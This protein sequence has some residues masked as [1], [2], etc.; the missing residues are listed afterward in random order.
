MSEE[1][2]GTEETRAPR[3]SLAIE[4]QRVVEGLRALPAHLEP[5][6]RPVLVVP[7]AILERL[8]R[9]GLQV[10]PV[11]RVC[12]GPLEHPDPEAFLDPAV[13]RASRSR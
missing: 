1:H 3:D 10:P 5:S 12:P 8:E 7:P 9:L 6:E 2:E 11:F 4:A 13:P